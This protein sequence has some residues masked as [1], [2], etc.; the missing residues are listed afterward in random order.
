MNFERKYHDIKSDYAFLT[1][2]ENQI[3][4]SIV[5]DPS[6][7]NF[8]HMLKQKEL[9][10]GQLKYE[11]ISATANIFTEGQQKDISILIN[12]ILPQFKFQNGPF[13]GRSII[14]DIE[15]RNAG[16]FG[17]TLFYKDLL[18]KILKINWDNF[19]D[20]V[21]E[22]K[23]ILKIFFDNAGNVKAIPHSI[24][25]I[26]GYITSNTL[27][28]QS[29][30]RI[31]P[32]HNII[33]FGKDHIYFKLYDYIL[34]EADLQSSINNIHL[35]NAKFMEGGIVTLFLDKADYDLS[36]Y[37]NAVFNL[38]PDD[39]MKNAHMIL[40]VKYMISG[41]S[42]FHETNRLIH[43]DI[44]LDNIVVKDNGM[45]MDHPET[46]GY[47]FQLI[48]FGLCSEINNIDHIGS[49]MG[50]TPS[51]YV[52]TI[53]MRYTSI[54]YDWYCI[55]IVLLVM[56]DIAVIDQ[57]GYFVFTGST[58]KVNTINHDG[59]KYILSQLP[60]NYIYPDI[61]KLIFYLSKTKELIDNA[62]SFVPYNYDGIIINSIND[63]VNVVKSFATDVN[64][65]APGTSQRIII[66]DEI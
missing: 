19:M 28:F 32:N 52:D 57:Q 43:N 39:T 61:M 21:N 20:I 53:F 55:Y 44:K 59:L 24:N 65:N 41:L 2:M 38:L 34:S 66:V 11:Q 29:V 15:V 8:I 36:A 31:R 17:I 37:K 14:N 22:I 48:D 12:F 3:G 4:G 10:T 35:N 47:T 64:M 54:L 62:G 49:R 26:Y 30:E 27:F 9:S 7:I 33:N 6:T 58:I 42:F 56:F 45:R 46:L 40:F 51:Y 13:I 1:K 25:K 60:T 16:S 18:I 50:G 63:F 23:I 5:F